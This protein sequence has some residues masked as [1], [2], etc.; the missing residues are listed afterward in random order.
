MTEEHLRTAVIKFK[1][2][3]ERT[4]K[5]NIRESVVIQKTGS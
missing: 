4:T 3:P 2:S 1:K 5:K